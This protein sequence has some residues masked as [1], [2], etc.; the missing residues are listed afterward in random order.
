M[1]LLTEKDI[2]KAHLNKWLFSNNFIAKTFQF[3]NFTEAMAFMLK[4]A[5]ICEKQNHHPN[6]SNIYNTVE[7]KLQTHDVGGVTNKDI[8]LA[9]E[10]DL[11][12]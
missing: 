5:F 2:E 1:A 10:I 9:K 4:V 6:W 8:A 3:K 7:I 12:F 11:L